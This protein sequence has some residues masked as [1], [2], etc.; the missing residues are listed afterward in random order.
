VTR[1]VALLLT[2]LTGF[3]GLV[4]EVTWQKYLATL[5]G[6]H[7]E[8][9]AAVLAIFLGGLSVGYALFGRITRARVARAREAE[10]RARLLLLYAA[11]EIGIGIFVL[12]FPSLF[13]AA[14]A[15]SLM[16]PDVG[17]GAGFAFDVL[18]SAL[19]IGPPAVLMGGTIPIL[20]LGLAGS[21][22]S[23]TRVHAWIYG[24]NT[25]GAF[26]GALGSTFFLIPSLGLDGVLYTLGAMNIAAGVVFGLLDLVGER[27]EPHYDESSDESTV[28]PAAFGIYSVVALLAGF[29][30]MALQTTFNRLGG[31]IFGSSHFTFGIV[32]AVFVL[33]IAMG[34]FA[35]SVFRVIPRFVI[36][37]SQWLLVILLV[38]L[39]REVGDAAYWAHVLRTLFR[40]VEPAFYAYHFVSFI[41]IFVVLMIPIGLSGALLPLLF[42]QLRGEAGDL[43]SV[44]GRLYSWNTAGSLLGAL[45]G[46]YVLLFWLDLDQIYRVAVAALVLAAALLTWIVY[47]ISRVA[48]GSLVVLPLIVG[49]TALPRWTPERLARGLFRSRE[50]VSATYAGPEVFFER[51]LEHPFIFHR[52]GPIASISVREGPPQNGL[53]NR[54]I[55]NNGKSDGNLIRDYSTMSLAALVPS[56]LAERNERCFVIGYGT[57]VTAGELAALDSV[58]SVEVAEISQAVIDAA[59]FFEDGNLAA[60]T[61]PKV[62]INRSDAYRALMR[63]DGQ[64]DVIV[65]EPSN[66]WVT[67]VEML[68]SV[69][70]LEAARDR[71]APG[72]VYAQWFHTYEMNAET[73][74]LVVRTYTSVFPH[75][76]VWYAQ[77]SDLLLLGFDRKSRAL[78]VLALEQRFERPDFRAGFGRSG[79]D[80]FLSLLAHEI[81]PLGTLHE[82]ELRGPVH[83]LRHPILSHQAARA[84][85]MGDMA[86]VPRFSDPDTARVGFNNSLLRLYA[87][88]PRQPL[89]EEVLEAV[90]RETCRRRRVSECG[91]L[92]AK[93]R[94]NHPDSEAYAALLREL[95]GEWPEVDV[96]EEAH[97]Q[98]LG[99]LFGRGQLRELDDRSSLS[100]AIQISMKYMDH[101]HYAVPFDRH[102][103]AAAWRLCTGEG[104]DEARRH[105]ESRLGPVDE[106]PISR[107]RRV[108]RERQERGDKQAGEQKRR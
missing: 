13:G 59:P 30:M 50:P 81:L 20:T 57:G 49:L 17:A 5:L 97:L 44:A 63:S 55:I 26:L 51:P 24:A 105:V 27:V 88:R 64:F 23:S 72:G 67:G 107:R 32:V 54:E 39:H 61:S 92:L 46:G 73:V 62:T 83:T 19:L 106:V 78:D 31:L 22:E 14:R 29:A 89:G 95:R 43:G 8:A 98:A 84:F 66:P 100:R 36:V 10:G 68:Y 41:G 12:L 34:S 42:H 7:G 52:D 35:V 15:A 99:K 65:S 86:R 37:G 104:C 70:F 60:S 80:D 47:G 33:C 74:E 71:L 1:L 102:I 93:W 85:F 38:V 79:V 94:R 4:Y 2:L 25:A 28:R 87:A 53:T 82:P 91:T 45:L 21:R 18:L 103:L 75:V 6:S 108:R 16:L 96:I 11:V 3:T 58:R 48:I 9:T 76:S 77:E 69:E 90:A 101:Y 40:S 56:L